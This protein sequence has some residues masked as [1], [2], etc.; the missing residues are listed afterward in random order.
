MR[1]NQ[2]RRSELHEKGDLSPNGHLRSNI[3]IPTSAIRY[4]QLSWKLPPFPIG[5]CRIGGFDTPLRV[6][7][8]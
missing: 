2:P 1:H 4:M 3:R 8:M 6:C 7:E 5:R